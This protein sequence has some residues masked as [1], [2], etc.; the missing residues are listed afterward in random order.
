MKEK[1][2]TLDKHIEM[3]YEKMKGIIIWNRTL[4]HNQHKQTI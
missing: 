1:K 2:E 3:L 4:R